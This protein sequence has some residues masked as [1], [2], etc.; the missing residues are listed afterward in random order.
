MNKRHQD[1]L[2]NL[3]EKAYFAGIGYVSWNEIYHW[4]NITR[5]GVLT[6]RNLQDRWEDISQGMAGRLLAIEQNDGLFLFGEKSVRPVVNDAQH[7]NAAVTSDKQSVE[8]S[9]I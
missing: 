5:L 4:Y 6:R 7:T 1:L 3:L 2:N 8:L 9:S